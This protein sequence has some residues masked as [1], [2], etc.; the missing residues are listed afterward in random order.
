[1]DVGGTLNG[2]SAARDRTLGGSASSVAC[3]VAFDKIVLL[4]K[5]P[6]Q[7]FGA[8]LLPSWHVGLPEARQI[9]RYEAKSISEKR[10]QISEHVTCAWKAL[11]QEQFRC[12]TPARFSIENLDS[13]N[14]CR[15]ISD[16]RLGNKSA[17][18]VLPWK[19]F[20]H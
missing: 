17:L 16:A 18:S 1:M 19:I 13:T 4:I 3:F 2:A 15:A 11:Q 9:G 10:Y 12:I 5:T 20:T 14:I 8:D 6:P 7:L